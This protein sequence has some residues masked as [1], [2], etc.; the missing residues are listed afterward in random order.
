[1][2]KVQLAKVTQLSEF[3]EIIDVRSPTEFNIDHIPCAISAPVLNNEE[4]ARIGTL[5]KQASPFEAKR[6][7]AA[8][9]ARNI[10]SHLETLFR[11]KP[12]E[13][14][15]LVYCW[16]GG[17]RSGGMAHILAQIGWRVGQL[18]GG[19]KSYRAHVIEALNLLPPRFQF[20]VI[21]GAT[22][23]GKSRLLQMLH[24][25]GAQVLDLEQ[26]AKHRGSLLGNLPNQAQPP[27]KMFESS[28]W[29]TLR[30]FDTSRPIFVEAESRKIGNLSMPTSLLE[31]IRQSQCIAIET[32]MSSRVQLLKEDYAHFLEDTGLLAKSLAPLRELHGDK[33]LQEWKEMAAQGDWQTFIADL[34]DRHYDPA[35]RR[36]TSSNFPLLKDAQQLHL[37]TLGEYELKIA[38]DELMKT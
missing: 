3:D 23:S 13:W 14:K 1:M 21:C 20:R 30:N 28:L 15:P 11:D 19:Y 22:G 5:Y 17:K 35:Y 16:R 32:N 4:R 38:A 9:I 34:L 8:L 10:A 31:S 37:S 12:R 33:V 2:R 27:Q 26:L 24:E 6:E 36:S 25:Q 18:E 7:G 29:D